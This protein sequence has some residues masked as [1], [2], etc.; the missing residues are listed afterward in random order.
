[1]KDSLR[2]W[3]FSGIRIELHISF[4][5]LMLFFALL[6]FKLFI[7][8]LALFFFVVL[9]ELSHSVVAMRYGVTI[10]RITLWPIGGI[11]AMDRIPKE[12]SQELQIALAGPLLNLAISA[13]LFLPLFL[14]GQADR[15]FPFFQIDFRYELVSLLV[16]M[17]KV[18][19]LLGAFNLLVPALPM[20]G[21]RIL[22][23]LLARRLPF[24]QATDIATDVAKVLATGM[25]VV[26]LLSFNLILMFIAIFVYLG[27]TQEAQITL[28]TTFLSGIHVEDLMSREVVTIPGESTLEEFAKRVME[29][30]HNGYPVMEDGRL[31]GLM[32]LKDLRKVPREEWG[33]RRVEE[34]MTRQFP[35]ASCREEAME[36][37]LRMYSTRSEV[38][39]VMEG[40]DLVGILS[41][42]DIY[43]MIEIMKALK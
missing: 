41:Q 38:M 13:L 2:I 37:L 6:N 35:T 17:M 11:S 4:V 40:E 20:D 36:A 3:T 15:I 16:V 22:R 9:H 1:M 18:N 26:S 14:T 34:A 24:S 32:T 42:V 21:G 39:P 12:P 29:T 25:F 28:L 5:L 43:R 10:E 33:S 23:A 19:F 27:A 30:K 8:L 31:L 7:Y